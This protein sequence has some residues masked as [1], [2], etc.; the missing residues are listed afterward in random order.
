MDDKYGS[1]GVIALHAPMQNINMQPEFEMLR[2]PGINNQIYRIELG[3]SD[4]ELAA[5]MGKS[6]SC[7]PDIVALGVSMEM[8]DW[9]VARQAEHRSVLQKAIGSTPLV[10]AADATVTA[11][12]AVGARRISILSPMGKQN[13]VSARAY[14]E[15]LGFEVAADYSLGVQR[16]SDI[17]KLSNDVIVQKFEEMDRPDV[18]TLL[19]VG[20]ALCAL[21]LVQQLEEQHNK[22]VIS[23]NAATYWMALRWLRVEDPIVGFGQLL[24][25]PL[26]EGARLQA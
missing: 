12:R 7:D 9:S 20:G 19:H 4:E 1:R 3:A 18:D 5:A 11:L 15:A 17:P 10:L 13:S 23:V 25:L 21:P 22:P 2:P 6:I 16:S 24:K 8:H 14:Y 26:P